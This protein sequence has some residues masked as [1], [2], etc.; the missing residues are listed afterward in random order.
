MSGK[1]KHNNMTYSNS[2]Y[3]SSALEECK[4]KNNQIIIN[5]L[6]TSKLIKGNED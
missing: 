5:K 2:P 3:N 1:L 4:A 6:T